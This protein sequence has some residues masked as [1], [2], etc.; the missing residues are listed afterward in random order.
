MI[1]LIK[2]RFEEGYYLTNEI[3]KEEAFYITNN[4]E[5]FNTFVDAFIEKRIDYNIDF[6]LGSELEKEL[7]K[8]F[9][10]KSQEEILSIVLE[11]VK[12]DI[13]SHRFHM[14]YLYDY[15][16][17]FGL[18]EE[19]YNR[20][21]DSLSDLFKEVG[22]V[23]TVAFDEDL[24]N[25]II[26]SKN[27]DLLKYVGIQDYDINQLTNPLK[28]NLTT[29]MS[30]L[31]IYTIS[32]YHIYNQGDRP[33]VT[34]DNFFEYLES[35]KDS[36]NDNFSRYFFS[37][38]FVDDT[39]IDKVIEN[40]YG[41]YLFLEDQE[42]TEENIAKIKEALAKGNNKVTK[43]YTLC[44]LEKI[45][46]E[47]FDYIINNCKIYKI[48]YNMLS[49]D[50]S[51]KE[52]KELCSK[53]IEKQLDMDIYG[54]EY[55]K[56]IIKAFIETKNYKRLSYAVYRIKDLSMYM[57]E[58]INSILKE[59]HDPYMYYLLFNHYRI[60]KIEELNFYT[61]ILDDPTF[62]SA[63]MKKVSNT[64]IINNIVTDDYYESIKHILSNNYH[65]DIEKMD[66][67]EKQF[68]PLIICHLEE[69]NIKRILSL[70]IETIKKIADLFPKGE[71]LLT[72]AKNQYESLKE[73]SFGKEEENKKVQEIFA[74]LKMAI[75]NND[76]KNIDYYKYQLIM[77]IEIADLLKLKEK[78]LVLIKNCEDAKID[79]KLIDGIN[80][81]M[82][83]MNFVE[84]LIDNPNESNLEMLRYIS[85]IAVMY[86][87]KFYFNNSYY[88]KEN[89]LKMPE[90]V[91]YHMGIYKEF[92][93]NY[94]NEIL[95]GVLK[96]YNIKSV[97]ELLQNFDSN[98]PKYNSIVEL[99]VRIMINTIREKLPIGYSMYD[100]MH[101]S[102][103][104]NER[105][106]NNELE[107]YYLA[108]PTKSIEEK[109][110]ERL[111]AEGLSIEL[112][113]KLLK[114]YKNSD[115]SSLE[116]SEIQY[117]KTFT[118]ISFD[119]IRE[120]IKSGKV[121]TKKITQKLD[122]ER[123]IER[124][125]KG[126]KDVDIF[127]I[128]QNLDIDLLLNGVLADDKLYNSLLE[129]MKVKKIHL[130]DNRI[131]NYITSSNL[132]LV[133]SPTTI[134][135]FINYYYKI[136]EESKS[137]TNPLDS[138]PEIIKFFDYFEILNQANSFTAS[139][140]MYN[141]IFGD[142]DAR[143]IKADPGSLSSGLESSVRF[144][145]AVDDIIKSYKK[146]ELAIPSCDK[147]VPLSSKK[148]IE[149]IVGNT[150]NPC[151]LT[152]GERTDACMRIGGIANALYRFAIDSPHGF[153]IRFEDPK[154]HKYISR[155]TGFRN[156]NSIFLNE[157]RESLDSY[158][159]DEDIIE[160]VQIIAKQLI[161]MTKD[162]EDPIENV[163]ITGEQIMQKANKKQIPTVSLTKLDVSEGFE[164]V[165]TDYAPSIPAR[166]LATSA[167][168]GHKK[169]E[170][171]IH[172]PKYK[173]QR[174]KPKIIINDFEDAPKLINKVHVIKQL[175]NGKKLEDKVDIL[176]LSDD[177]IYCIA[178]DDWYIYITRDFTMHT[179]VIDIDPRAIEEFNKYRL[180][181]EQIIEKNMIKEKPNARI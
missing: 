7:A 1:E 5:L 46:K 3:T 4:K 83:I 51:D 135:D 113:E 33:H 86:E 134:A 75:N 11:L 103:D 59:K 32:H 24:I 35:V 81:E 91:K 95:Q 13:I 118:K 48:N 102:Y 173:T 73:H 176:D 122:I 106:A 76:K 66:Y 27:Y 164:K 171:Y 6:S 116:N 38:S 82:N 175:I 148:S 63:F 2:Q 25:F 158:Y 21:L 60:K 23:R 132:G 179:E 146:T 161:E 181:V 110:K 49:F 126:S 94:S 100:E 53:L 139:S 138:T 43:L 130:F 124:K 178:N 144:D 61:P 80:P 56:N 172:P 119:V 79:K 117:I 65:I 98:D 128:L 101:L 45:D 93:S 67:L 136:M 145:I 17:D 58:E 115:F 107:K 131:F 149:V 121:D 68:G 174:S 169:I 9:N 47:I 156:G 166:L 105:K 72:D 52:K 154:T 44:D 30:E 120:E 97:E 78:L 159:S 12:K 62:F 50:D 157:L 19:T 180:I 151:N 64:R 112:I 74:S 42:L 89:K 77:R 92:I 125:F 55:D 133:I 137:A 22:E 140:N 152:H 90:V 142:V 14:K 16:N 70:D 123:K 163:F 127:L 34:S 41:L 104:L 8:R 88:M 84:Y 40:G 85:N 57:D 37:F 162:S 153:H 69:E 177:I 167:E 109:I 147:V 39:Y 26:N 18:E 165:Y 71:F 99:L 87:R 10:R 150:T 36:N 114:C 170:H 54:L 160:A 29:L 155:V 31:G 28:G 111:T 143:L 108:N 20:I 129:I 96:K 141:I 168:M 15:S